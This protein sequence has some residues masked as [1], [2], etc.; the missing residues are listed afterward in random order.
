MTNVKLMTYPQY[1]I[2]TVINLSLAKTEEICLNYKSLE[3][4]QRHCNLFLCMTIM[5]YSINIKHGQRFAH[6]II[7]IWQGL[8]AAKAARKINVMC[9]SPFHY[10]NEIF[11]EQFMGITYLNVRGACKKWIP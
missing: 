8:H 6:F 2:S 1:C 9:C 10:D 4:K 7:S 3:L 5:E 11:Q